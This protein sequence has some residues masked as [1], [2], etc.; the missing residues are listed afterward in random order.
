MWL[1]WKGMLMAAI[2]KHI[3]LKSKVG[4]N[5][6]SPWITNQLR[7]EMQKRDFLKKKAAMDGNPFT[8]DE[9]KRARNNTNNEEGQ[10]KIFHGKLEVQQIKSQKNVEIN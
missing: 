9:Y 1:L 2:D 10:A 4:G 6:K 5:K 7:N 8:W 3:S